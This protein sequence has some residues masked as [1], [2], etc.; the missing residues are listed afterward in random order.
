MSNLFGNQ[1]KSFLAE[2][3]KINK[4]NLLAFGYQKL[5]VAGTV[6][7][8]TIP[9][10]AT[11]ALITVESSLTTPAIRYLELNL[12]TPPSATDGM[13]R[14]N[15]DTF[16]ITGA[17]NLVNFRAIQIAAGTHTLHIQYYK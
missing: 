10:G 2:L 1:S 3:V 5:T 15:L 17:S 14:S 8:L 6:V 11:Y 13:S 4:S 9:T 7:G 16:D 12:V